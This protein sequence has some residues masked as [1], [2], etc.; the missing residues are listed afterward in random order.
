MCEFLEFLLWEK[1]VSISL[2]KLIHKGKI[3]LLYASEIQSPDENHLLY[4][5]NHAYISIYMYFH[6]L[7]NKMVECYMF[8]FLNITFFIIKEHK[9][10]N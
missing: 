5:I 1:V 3:T 2:E 6:T 4:K 9:S 7:L 8:C 10:L